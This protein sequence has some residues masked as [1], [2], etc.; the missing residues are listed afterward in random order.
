MHRIAILKFSAVFFINIFISFHQIVV[1][2]TQTDTYIHIY[3][4]AKLPIK[5]AL[6]LKKI[7]AWD[8]A[9]INNT[10]FV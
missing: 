2:K 6:Q 4:I 7:R 8:A 9:K 1:A 10:V 5:L 3:I